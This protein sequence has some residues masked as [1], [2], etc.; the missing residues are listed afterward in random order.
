VLDKQSKEI[1]GK[2]AG[3]HERNVVEEELHGAPCS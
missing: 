3:N 2:I 1:R